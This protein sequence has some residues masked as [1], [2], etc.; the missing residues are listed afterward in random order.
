M[1][2]LRRGSALLVLALAAAAGGCASALL[3]GDPSVYER[4]IHRLSPSELAA[5]DDLLERGRTAPRVPV[6]LLHL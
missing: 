2:R 6:D 1:L 5:I 3:R 4:Q